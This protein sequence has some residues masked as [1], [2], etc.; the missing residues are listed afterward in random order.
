MTPSPSRLSATGQP[1]EPFRPR[2]RPHFTDKQTRTAK[3]GTKSYAI[4]V[5]FLEMR[6]RMTFPKAHLRDQYKLRLLEAH[7]TGHIFCPATGEYVSPDELQD[8]TRREHEERTNTWRLLAEYIATEGNDWTRNTAMSHRSAFGGFIAGI[9]GNPDLYATARDAFFE[10]R[11]SGDVDD[12]AA[13]TLVSA[14][15]PVAELTDDVVAE[16]LDR[17]ESKPKARA[18]ARATISG[19]TSY[20][21]RR[22]HVPA[23]PM[24]KEAKVKAGGAVP[25]ERHMVMDWPLLMEFVMTFEI[26]VEQ[27]LLVLMGVGGLRPSEAAGLRRRDV[28]PFDGGYLLEVGSQLH[29][30]ESRTPCK[31]RTEASPARWVPIVHQGAVELLSTLLETTTGRPDDLLCPG[32][33]G[34]RFNISAWAH[35]HNRGPFIKLRDEFFS[36]GHSRWQDSADSM[37]SAA[38]MGRYLTPH[39]LRHTACSMWLTTPG[40][41]TKDVQE[42]GGWNDESTMLRFYRN[43]LPGSRGRSI[44]ALRNV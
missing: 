23:D 5:N 4:R 33:G 44:E 1:T 35:K 27:V 12:D 3:D 17:W 41:D 36:T 21:V 16:V 25:I 39:K 11:S 28:H 29:A 22:K 2:R 30:D 38:M 6:V 43:I 10:L 15:P 8:M 20:L 14:T 19:F 18:R 37:K 40:V 34:R 7:H 32:S 9:S 31:A 42:W 24:P 26:L 13:T